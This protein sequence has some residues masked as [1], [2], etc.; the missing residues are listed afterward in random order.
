MVSVLTIVE[1][2]NDVSP[3]SEEPGL[4][5]VDF[6]S[7]DTVVIFPQVSSTTTE[8]SESVESTPSLVFFDSDTTTSTTL[9]SL[10]AESTTEFV[11]EASS[12]SESVTFVPRSCTVSLPPVSPVMIPGSWV[13]D[14]HLYVCRQMIPHWF[15][16]G[17]LGIH[18]LN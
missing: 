12:T 3:T 15:Q 10:P 17:A 7:S 16:C 18:N 4:V 8:I 9:Y 2:T 13:N 14:T 11:S 6:G 1:E 5:L